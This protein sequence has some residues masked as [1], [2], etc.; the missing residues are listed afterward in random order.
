MN[1]KSIPGNVFAFILVALLIIA[2][3]VLVALGHPIPDIFSTLAYV[4]VG[5][6]GGASLPGLNAAPSAPPTPASTAP[7]FTDAGVVPV[8]AAPVVQGP[9]PVLAPPATPPVAPVA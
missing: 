6:G 5:V 1:I 2:I 3:V 8:A 4:L 7:R 9:A